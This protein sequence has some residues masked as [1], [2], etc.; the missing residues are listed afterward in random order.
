MTL[1]DSSN[2][3]LFGSAKPKKKKKRK[4][5]YRINWLTT[6]ATMATVYKH[7]LVSELRVASRTDTILS[8]K[9]IKR[10]VIGVEQRK[11]KVSV[12]DKNWIG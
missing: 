8:T 9:N 4:R 11:Y 3:F 7:S 1:R 2:R 5:K 10:R 6:A 12:G